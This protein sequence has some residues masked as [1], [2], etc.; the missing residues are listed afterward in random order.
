M[1]PRG[2]GALLELSNDGLRQVGAPA[3]VQ[4]GEVLGATASTSAVGSSGR[5]VGGSSTA[6]AAG[7]SIGAATAT[8]SA[9]GRSPAITSGATAPVSATHSVG[10]RRVDA[11]ATGSVAA[12]PS[13]AIRTAAST[14]RASTSDIARQDGSGDR[15]GQ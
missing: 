2:A 9:S 14:V 5:S 6:T 4:G 3:Q 15:S 10:A 7:R 13:P 1:G 11:V 8:G 12:A